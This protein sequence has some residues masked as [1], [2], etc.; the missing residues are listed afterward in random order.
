MFDEQT[1][2]RFTRLV[3][4]HHAQN[5]FKTLIMLFFRKS[6]GP[7]TS[8]LIFPTAKYTNTQIHIYK[9]TNTAYDEVPGVFPKINFA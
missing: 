7:K 2:T 6:Q 8:K 5:I 1:C 4:R 9:Y 3:G